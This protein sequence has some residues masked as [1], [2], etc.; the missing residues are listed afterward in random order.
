MTVGEIID[1]L[2]NYQEDIPVTMLSL[3][4][5]NPLED[6]IGVK[7]IIAI[8]FSDGSIRIVIRPE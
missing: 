8:S 4:Q 1:F 7:E 6:D 3:N 2:K 5:D